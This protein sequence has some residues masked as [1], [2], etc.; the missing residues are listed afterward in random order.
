MTTT[1][2]LTRTVIL[3]RT[4]SYIQAG[5][6]WRGRFTEWGPADGR[7]VIVERSEAALLDAA[8]T[9][10]KWMGEQGDRNGTV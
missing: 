9:V 10:A 5:N 1:Q 8:E 6:E 3:G 7:P 4:F 2:P